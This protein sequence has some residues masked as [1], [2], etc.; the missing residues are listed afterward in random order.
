MQ[1]A[2]RAVLILG[3]HRSGTSLCSKI[4]HLMGFEAPK[5]LMAANEANPNMRITPSNAAR[6]ATRRF[7]RSTP[8]FLQVVFITKGLFHSPTASRSIHKR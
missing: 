6:R 1:P 8:S 7:G 2:K 3:M 5:T 4:V